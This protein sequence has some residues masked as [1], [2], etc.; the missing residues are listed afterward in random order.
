MPLLISLDV[1]LFLLYMLL[2]EIRFSEFAFLSCWF[3]VGQVHMLSTIW[4]LREIELRLV[5][6][7]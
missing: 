1:Q 2:H 4:V 7:K 6:R 3:C 5:P